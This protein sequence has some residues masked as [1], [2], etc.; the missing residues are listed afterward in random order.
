MVQDFSHQQYEI[1]DT[2][3]ANLE[4]RESF[5]ILSAT[6]ELLELF[7][8]HGSHIALFHSISVTVSIFHSGSPLTP[9]NCDSRTPRHLHPCRLLKKSNRPVMVWRLLFTA[10][11]VFGVYLDF[12]KSP[13]LR[14]LNMAMKH[15]PIVMDTQLNGMYFSQQKRLSTSPV[16]LFC[17]QTSAEIEKTHVN[18]YP[19]TG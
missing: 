12:W 9:V 16:V 19:G 7:W 4:A 18:P 13:T 17:D 2:L 3:W 6:I 14:S 1:F 11:P 15:P 5:N 8:I 10:Y